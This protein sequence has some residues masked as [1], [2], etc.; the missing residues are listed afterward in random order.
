MQGNQSI[1]KWVFSQELQ[2]KKSTEK[3]Y[4]S[5]KYNNLVVFIEKMM[6]ILKK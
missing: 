4:K 5:L 6:K 3:R 1:K 2:Q